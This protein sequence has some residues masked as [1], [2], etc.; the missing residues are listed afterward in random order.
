[1][2]VRG[3]CLRYRPLQGLISPFE[4]HFGVLW[5]IAREQAAVTALYDGL[6]AEMCIEKPS[7]IGIGLR[8]FRNIYHEK[9]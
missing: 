8:D 3:H 7:N 6:V 9:A 1:M 2:K 5:R 4:K